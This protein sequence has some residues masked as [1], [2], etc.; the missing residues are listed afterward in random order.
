MR[1]R[2]DLTDYQKQFIK[3]NWD[4]MTF[5]QIADQLG[6]NSVYKVSAFCNKHFLTKKHKRTLTDEQKEFIR[7]NLFI[8][9]ESEMARELGVSKFYIQDFKRSEGLA[10]NPLH[11]KKQ[12]NPVVKELFFNVDA[13]EC[14]VA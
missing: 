6:F 1:P 5:L 8:L 11:R 9:K 10:K 2:T 3:D 4:R 7:K 14:W 13:R 12:R